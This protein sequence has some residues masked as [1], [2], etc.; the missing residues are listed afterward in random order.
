MDLSSLRHILVELAVLVCFDYCEYVEIGNIFISDMA[1]CVNIFDPV[2][3]GRL[4]K[5]M[6]ICISSTLWRIR[7]IS[8]AN[9]FLLRLGKCLRDFFIG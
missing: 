5:R 7:S 9:S 6:S 2:V 1:F 3:S 4:A 8:R